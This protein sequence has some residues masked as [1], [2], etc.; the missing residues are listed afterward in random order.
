MAEHPHARIPEPVNPGHGIET[1]ETEG[2]LLDGRVRY[3][4]PEK[5]F[6]SGIEPVLLAAAIP[7]SAGE[8]VIEGGSG[9]GAGLL[10]LAA[11]VGAITGIGIER[12][13]AL[14]ALARRN[15]LA[16]AQPR[17]HFIAGDIARLPCTGPADHAFANPP[18]HPAQGTPSPDPARAASK[19]G[20]ES[21]FAVWTKA[22]AATLK[23]GGTITLIAPAARLPACLEA[24]AA[25]K[26]GSGSLFPLWPRVDSP[27]KLVLV[28][29]IRL[30]RSAFR[31]LPG[32]VL[33]EQAGGY[34]AAAQAVLRHGAAITM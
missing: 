10:C 21:V 17:L 8:R 4:Q 26:C 18:Y 6:R 5:G 32:L 7:A 22:L 23:T 3:A 29:A 2:S 1:A 16:N 11:R 24:L 27:A 14:A 31:V 13:P 19:Q 34:T 28:R 25:A 15:A 12:N 33:H 30:G 9:A 20:S